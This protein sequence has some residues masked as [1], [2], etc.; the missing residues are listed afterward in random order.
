MNQKYLNMKVQIISHLCG[1]VTSFLIFNTKYNKVEPSAPGSAL[2][3]SC[4]GP[5]SK[6]QIVR[7]KCSVSDPSATK[8]RERKKNLEP[9]DYK[10]SKT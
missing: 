10:G 9:T 5:R 3:D 2:A 8:A 6:L 4:E 1:K 7:E